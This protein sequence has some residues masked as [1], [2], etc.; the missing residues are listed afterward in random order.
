MQTKSF[1]I[2]GTTISFNPYYLLSYHTN[3][4][5]LSYL[6]GYFLVPYVMYEGACKQVSETPNRIY[7]VRY[8]ASRLNRTDLT[9]ST[10]DKAISDYNTNLMYNINKSVVTNDLQYVEDV[11]STVP[12]NEQEKQEEEVTEPATPY[13][14][15]A[16]SVYANIIK[17]ELK[18]KTTR[19]TFNLVPDDYYIHIKNNNVDV[20][21][22]NP[23]I[24]SALRDL[25]YASIDNI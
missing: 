5:L 12:F 1:S 2:I 18:S 10:I 19:I 6:T 20:T 22:T 13:L 7:Y 21:I 9:T 4:I 8:M 15:D 23:S 3:K 24:I 11:I 25:F 16:I 17:T 14:D